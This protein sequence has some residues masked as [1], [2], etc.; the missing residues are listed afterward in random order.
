[1]FFTLGTFLSRVTGLLRESIVAGIFGANLGLDAFIIANR[2]PNMLRELLAEGALGSSFTAEY[3]KAMSA[4][5]QKGQRLLQDSLVFFT[6][7]S[8]GICLLGMLTASYWVHVITFFGSHNNQYDV[9]FAKTTELTQILFPFLVFMA[10]NSILSGSLHQK[11]RFFVSAFSPILVNIG[12][13]TGAILFSGFFIQRWNHESSNITPSI[14]GL[15]WG[16]VIGGL[17]QTLL[18][19]YSVRK[20]NILSKDQSTTKLWPVPEHVKKIISTAF[21]MVI[22]GSAA[23]I[24]IVVNSNFA[25]SLPHGSVSW[26]NLSFRLIQLPIGLFAVGLG[27]AIL[28]RLSKMI[29]EESNSNNHKY[30]R[31]LAKTCEI[32]L[33]LILPCMILLLIE[34]DSIV[35]L[36]YEHGRF[37][38][39]DS[40]HTGQSLSLYALA[41]PGYALI[42]VL[43][44][45]YYASGRTQYAMKVSLFG[46]I[47]NFF[48]GYF[49]VQHLGHLGLALSFSVLLTVNAFFLAAGSL[50]QLLTIS[51]KKILRSVFLITLA[52]TLSYFALNMIDIKNEFILPLQL[53]FKFAQFLS[54][55]IHSAIIFIFYFVFSC[56]RFKIKSN[57]LLSSLLN[58]KKGS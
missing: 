44:S 55:V 14:T 8:I 17:L 46:V 40:I 23:Q 20:K 21:P 43:T 1:M 48:V 26:L 31:E 56:Y 11:G 49:F 58:I 29:S 42:K 35:R 54:I 3:S 33:W 15:A 52:S 53:P 50:L 45:F 28:P 12:Y 10:I 51:F 32:V 25:T 13:I 9:F 38:T 5:P 30:L 7:I 6:I 18:L 19:Y 41:L 57:T 24:N 2:I 37:S 34:S 39:Q 16:V 4:D 27:I 22:A 47:I 36:L